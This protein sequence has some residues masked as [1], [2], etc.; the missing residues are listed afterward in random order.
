M[1]TY[2]DVL[3]ELALM[4]KDS[5]SSTVVDL[6][7]SV[8]D[9]NSRF[10]IETADLDDEEATVFYLMDKL[11]LLVKELGK[12]AY[13]LSVEDTSRVSRGLADLLYA[14]LSVTLVLDDLGTAGIRSVLADNDSKSPAT[15]I[16][17]ASKTKLLRREEAICRVCNGVC[18]SA[19]GVHAACRDIESLQ[20]SEDTSHL[21]DADDDTR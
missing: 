21:D 10:E 9:F 20:H 2:I 4:D 6:A 8:Y 17:N 14:T 15:H 12:V 16:M 13:A 3:E 11:P 19:S 7:D 18:I 1:E 5:F